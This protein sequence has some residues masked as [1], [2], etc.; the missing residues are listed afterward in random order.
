MAAHRSV[1][2]WNAALGP[3]ADTWE[4]SAANDSAGTQTLPMERSFDS[5][6]RIGAPVTP[7]RRSLPHA[8][9]GAG[10]QPVAAGLTRKKLEVG[11]AAPAL[12]AR[13]VK[14]AYLPD[15]EHDLAGWEQRQFGA[16]GSVRE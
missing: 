4:Q 7:G 15:W 1:R 10:P 3:V 16:H 11:F 5:E 2:G 9:S 14:I 8:Q 13:T 12:P 6:A